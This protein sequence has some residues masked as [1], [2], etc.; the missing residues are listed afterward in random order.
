M[1]ILGKKLIVKAGGTA[2]AAAK[3]CEISITTKQIDIASPTSGEWDASILGRKS[4]KV[5][6]NHLLTS[7]VK[8]SQ[9]AG[10]TVSL[11]IE[12]AG[13]VG[14]PFDGFVDNVTVQ[15][16]A[17]TRIPESIVWDKTRKKFLGATTSIQ[18]TEYYDTWEGGEAYT[19][20]SAYQLFS[21]QDSTYIWLSNTLSAEKLT[22]NAHVITWKGSGSVGNIATGSFEFRG[23]G[24]L[25]PASLPTA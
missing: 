11:S 23:T 21:C 20:P 5:R 4:W 10:T 22:G 2:I 9:M 3:S 6:T 14:L 16:T 17:L 15:Q 1:Y 12:I 8:T 7:L 18:P 19:S 24:P 25:T 13:G